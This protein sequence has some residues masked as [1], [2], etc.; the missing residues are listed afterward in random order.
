M[1]TASGDFIDPNTGQVIPR[2]GPFHYGHKPGFEWWRTQQIA[3]EQGWT[4]EQLIEYEN[5]P[6]HYQIEDPL[7]NLSHRFEMPRG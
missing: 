3:R 7:A 5:N 1:R 2:G 6:S 4:R